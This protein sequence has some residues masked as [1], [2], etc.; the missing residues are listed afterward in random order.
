VMS[1]FVLKIAKHRWSCRNIFRTSCL[2]QRR[3]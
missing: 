1:L 3:L 2:S